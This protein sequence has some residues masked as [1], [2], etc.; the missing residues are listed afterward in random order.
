MKKSTNYKK[1]IPNNIKWWWATSYT[2][3]NANNI[4]NDINF[5]N[6]N[7]QI[8][9]EQGNIYWKK[10]KANHCD[11]SDEVQIENDEINEIENTSDFN[12]F[13]QKK[14][15]FFHNGRTFQSSLN[16]SSIFLPIKL[17]TTLD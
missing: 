3:E 12:T 2:C 8:N 13:K 7:D 10:N 5:D 16:I 15:G 4:N 1:L 6:T 11:N 14:L 17:P 9:F